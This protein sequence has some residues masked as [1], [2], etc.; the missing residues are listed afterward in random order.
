MQT[1]G[2]L[3]YSVTTEPKVY[4]CSANSYNKTFYILKKTFHTKFGKLNST[5]IQHQISELQTVA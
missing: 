3:S 1:K 5:H 2:F 4:R